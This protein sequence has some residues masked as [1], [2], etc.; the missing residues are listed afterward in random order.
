LRSPG[1]V[2]VTVTVI[3]PAVPGPGPPQPEFRYRASLSARVVPAGRRLSRGSHDVNPVPAP[4]KVRGGEGSAILRLATDRR[5]HGTRAGSSR[6]PRSR[7]GHHRSRRIRPGPGPGSPG[8][9]GGLGP[10]AAR[11]AAWRRNRWVVL[12]HFRTS[13]GLGTLYRWPKEGWVRARQVLGP[14]PVS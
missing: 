7:H 2:T 12:T 9:G 5:R 10:Q 3:S 4:C 11:A 1:T 6:D 14:C 13:V 8:P